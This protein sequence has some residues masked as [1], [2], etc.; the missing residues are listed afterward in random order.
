[1][2]GANVVRQLPLLAM[3]APQHCTSGLHGGARAPTGTIIAA[4]CHYYQHIQACCTYRCGDHRAESLR[5]LRS[6]HDLPRTTGS[7][8]PLVPRILDA[9]TWLTSAA[10]AT[11]TRG[12]R[13]P[14][15][16][17]TLRGSDAARDRVHVGSLLTRETGRD[18]RRIRWYP[19]SRSSSGPCFRTHVQMTCFTDKRYEDR[20]YLYTRT[21]ARLRQP[22]DV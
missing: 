10:S 14:S 4:T 21:Q 7:D 2:S 8:G 6:E 11:L 17:Q 1:M 16:G 3:L 15:A 19:T 5:C 18:A 20:E 13:E 9:T 22:G 12:G